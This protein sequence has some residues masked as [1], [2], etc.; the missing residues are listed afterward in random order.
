V[1]GWLYLLNADESTVAVVVPVYN[2]AEILPEMIARLS[3]MGLDELVFVDGRSSDESELILMNSGLKWMTS[4]QGRAR[5]MNAG[6][7]GCTSDI[8]VFIH[9]DTRF[10]SSCLTSMKRAL[11]EPAIV[12]GRFDVRL[13]GDSF[14]FR[15]IEHFINLR[16]R[17]SKIS[18][19]DQCIFVRRALFEKMGGFAELPLMEDVEFSKRLKREG[20]IACMK[21]KVVTSSRRWEKKGIVRTI[22]LMW[23]LRFLYW[24]GTSPER[25]AELYRYAR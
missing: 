2:E 3:E 17:I 12:G 11:E 4:E 7:S 13:S 6:A 15:L 23:K 20:V 22:L 25:L 19:G 14:F 24:A 18:T 16:S 5:Q 8:L 10:S 21:E 1:A 9:A